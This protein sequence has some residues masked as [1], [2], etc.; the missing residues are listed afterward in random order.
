MGPRSCSRGVTDCK[1][2]H[3]GFEGTLFLTKLF[4]SGFSTKIYYATKKFYTPC[5]NIDG[6]AAYSIHCYAVYTRGTV[7]TL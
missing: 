4:V 2:E 3:T 5:F 6:H 7:D 1:S